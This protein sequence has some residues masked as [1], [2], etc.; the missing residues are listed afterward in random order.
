MSLPTGP[1]GSALLT[2][3][4]LEESSDGIFVFDREERV[5]V[6]NPAMER[7]FGVRAERVLGRQTIEVFPTLTKTGVDR[8]HAAA[9]AGE[10]VTLDGQLFQMPETR[11][12]LY[13]DLRYIPLMNRYGYVT[14]VLGIAR[15]ALQGAGSVRPGSTSVPVESALAGGWRYGTHR[16]VISAP[17]RRPS[18]GAGGGAG[19]DATLATTAHEL[20]TPINAILGYVE[21]LTQELSGPVTATQ[22]QY[23]AHIARGARHLLS[24]A[25]RILGTAK[26]EAQAEGRPRGSVESLPDLTPTLRSPAPPSR[27][28]S[29]WRE[30]TERATP[31]SQRG[32][33]S[34]AVATA[35]VLVRPQAD[36]RGITL[37]G[38]AEAADDLWYYGDAEWV[39]RILVNLLSNAIKFTPAGG[40]VIV[41]AGEAAQPEWN[42]GLAAVAASP[43]G[44]RM[45]PAQSWTYLRVDDTGIGI[46]PE[47]LDAVFRPFVQ[48]AMA[49]PSAN[50]TTPAGTGLGLTIS[51]RL[52]RKMG[53][54]IT[55]TSR[56]NA[57]SRFTLWLPTNEPVFRVLYAETAGVR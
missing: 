27:G 35:L 21:L 2:E 56:V 16:H 44:N 42:A 20:R 48:G 12:T 37:S 18:H 30:E 5:V 29:A 13:V 39:T 10:T 26:S 47:Q 33:V 55:V 49:Q 54:E 7:L 11:R 25:N 24:I 22:Q 50:E 32:K 19:I 17:T 15:E 45:A 51:R 41:F 14:A 31:Q 53:G 1:G 23:L 46:P 6:W 36:A 4:L 9:L 38:G 52:A 40:R 28:M 34:D 8:H 57:G 3:R 43:G